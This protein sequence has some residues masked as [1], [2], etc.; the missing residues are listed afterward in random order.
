MVILFYIE[1]VH[2]DILHLKIFS[3][4]SCVKSYVVGEFNHGAFD[5][6]DID[7]HQVCFRKNAI[8]H[9]HIVP[10]FGKSAI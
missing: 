7:I 6:R 5:E 2:T 8:K 3:L 10:I 1:K 4:Y 9:E